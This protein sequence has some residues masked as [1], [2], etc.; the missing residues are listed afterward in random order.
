MEVGTG[1]GTATGAGI[2]TI[3]SQVTVNATPDSDHKFVAWRLNGSD[4]NL[5]TSAQYTFTL[6]GQTDLVAVFASNSG[7]INDGVD[8]G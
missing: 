3:G 5:S 7:S 8:E 2:F 6:E 1:G 4:A